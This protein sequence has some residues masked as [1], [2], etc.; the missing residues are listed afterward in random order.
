[1]MLERRLT[2]LEALAV[3]TTPRVWLEDPDDG[4][5]VCQTTG[6]RIAVQDAGR[7]GPGAIVVRY[8]DDW[9]GHEPGT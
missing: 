9:R 4:T 2:R 6:A 5:L 3:P 1:M 8:V 7:L